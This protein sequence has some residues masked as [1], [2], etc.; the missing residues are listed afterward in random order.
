MNTVFIM[1][2]FYN[3]L[4]NSFQSG[5]RETLNKSS[6]GPR[7]NQGGLGGGREGEREMGESGIGLKERWREREG[8]SGSRGKRV[9]GRERARGWEKEWGRVNK[10]GG[11]REGYRERVI[12]GGGGVE[13]EIEDRQN[14]G[15]KGNVVPRDSG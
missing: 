5:F 3:I 11:K 1:N 10:S 8:K 12:E 14:G 4:S 6:G 13:R 7:N 2:S 9:G 15:R